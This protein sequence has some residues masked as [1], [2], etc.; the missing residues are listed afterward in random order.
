MTEVRQLPLTLP[1]RTALGRDD[2]LVAD[3]NREAVEWIDR[4][5]EWPGHALAIFGPPGSG[6]THLACVWQERTGVQAVSLASLDRDTLPGSLRQ[7]LVLEDDGEPFDEVALLHAYNATAQSGG[8]LLITSRTAPARWP[9]RLPDLYS[10]LRAVLSVE[11][12]PPDDALLAAVLTKLFADRQIS[13]GPEVVSYIVSRVERSF[14]AA[15]RVVA[16]LDAASLASGQRVTVPFT[17]K[18]L[19]GMG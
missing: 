4:W 19:G 10:R 5:P 12:G 16:D 1:A 7:G 3:S 6:K 17:S 15:A 18:I 2:F 13:V 14:A 8:S 9:V 11:V